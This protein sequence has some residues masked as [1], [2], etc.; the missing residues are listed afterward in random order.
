VVEESNA[1]LTGRQPAAKFHVKMSG[2]EWQHEIEAE[3]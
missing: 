2:S 1:P 3:G